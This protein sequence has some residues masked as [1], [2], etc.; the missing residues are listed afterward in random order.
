MEEQWDTFEAYYV[1]RARTPGAK[2]ALRTLMG[3]LGTPVIPS[4]DLER[5]AVPTSL[6]WGR[7]N[8]GVRVRIAETASARHGWPLYVIEDAGDDPALERPDAFLDALRQALANGTR[9][10]REQ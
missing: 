3:K 6:I 1:D 2:A 5:I 4:E 7:E 9:I 8:L 10:K